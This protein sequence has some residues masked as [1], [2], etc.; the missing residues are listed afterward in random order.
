MF[1]CATD[2]CGS[3]SVEPQRV[4]RGAVLDAALGRL[5][6]SLH[7]LA[8]SGEDEVGGATHTSTRLLAVTSGGW[9]A[10][11]LH[12][13]GGRAHLTLAAVSPRAR[14][15]VE[16]LQPSYGKH[17][18]KLS[19]FGD[20]LTHEIY[21]SDY[22]Y[23][24]VQPVA[25]IAWW[26]T[27]CQLP[28]TANSTAALRQIASGPAAVLELLRA[29]HLSKSDEDVGIPMSVLQHIR[30]VFAANVHFLLKRASPRHFEN[31]Q[32]IRF[33]H[34]SQANLEFICQMPKVR[35]LYLSGLPSTE[36]DVSA[37]A[38]TEHLVRLALHDA[39][40]T[41]IDGLHTCTSL[42]HLDISYC[43]HM[44]DLAG[45]LEVPW[46]KSLVATRSGL[47]T[48]DGLHRLSL[49]ETVSLEC[50]KELASLA[51]LAGARRLRRLTV[52]WSRVHDIV[53]LNACPVLEVVDVSYCGALHSL[54]PL[55][56][57]PSLH[58]IRAD[59][60]GIT[61]IDGL[62][63]C[64]R[65]HTVSFDRCSRLHSLESLAGAPVL[66]C[67]S[68]RS[69]G[70]CDIGRL[71]TCSALETVDFSFCA[72]LRELTLLAG[73]QRLQTV[74]AVGSGVRSAEG[75]GAC[76]LLRRV[77]LGCA[78]APFRQKR[79]SQRSG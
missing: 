20:T 1:D 12:Y 27:R 17:N 29:V 2:N 22:R 37:F 34:V 75:L 56:G 11:V 14:L 48:I 71:F 18:P 32:S 5:R 24:P 58:T 19:I 33:F 57:A 13:T 35:D 7:S 62:G 53:G 47:Q 8:V 44:R 16:L 78:A 15:C 6:R 10:Q 73:A 49:L 66:R 63:T 43:L 28:L 72:D 52:R 41:S 70:L 42:D 59:A 50:C 45:V 67:I 69:A 9:L 26:L 65:L 76:P 3:D 31:L 46:L 40:L 61:D 30:E 51:P 68:M 55:A 21:S 25:T 39:R 64:P 38:S 23:P 4:S 79:L 77:D 74:V 54:G 36:L 60:S